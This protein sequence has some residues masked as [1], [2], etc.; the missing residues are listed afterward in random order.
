MVPF[1]SHG[2]EIVIAVIPTEQIKVVTPVMTITTKE[3]AA[4]RISG[5]FVDGVKVLKNEIDLL[6][7]KAA[8]QGKLIE[9]NYITGQE[10]KA[11]TRTP[12]RNMK[13]DFTGL[14]YGKKLMTR[15]AAED[16]GWRVIKEFSG[17]YALNVCEVEEMTA[18]EKI[19]A[20]Y[21]KLVD[22]AD[23]MTLQGLCL[24]QAEQLFIFKT[25]NPSDDRGFFDMA[26]EFKA[27][28]A[29][30]TVDTNETDG[31]EDDLDEEFI[32]VIPTDDSE[33]DDDELI[34]EPDYWDEHITLPTFEEIEI[35]D[36][37]NKPTL[38]SSNLEWT[39]LNVSPTINGFDSSTM[40]KS[41]T[42]EAA[43]IGNYTITISLK[44]KNN[45]QWAGGSTSDV[46]LNW[47]IVRKKLTAAQS[48][49]TGSWVFYD[50]N[51]K[52][53]R[54]YVT[55]IDDTYHTFTGQTSGTNAGTYSISISPRETYA[56]SD[57]TTDAKVTSMTITPMRLAK[58]SLTNTTFTYDSTAHS[59]TI[60]NFNSTY[61]N[62]VGSDTATN[63]GTYTLTFSLKNS[64]NTTWLDSTTSNVECTWTI[65]KA[66]PTLTLS[67]NSVTLADSYGAQATVDYTY[68]GDGTVSM[69]IPA[70]ADSDALTVVVE[71]SGLV[72]FT[73][74]YR[75]QAITVK[76]NASATKNYNAA[77]ATLSV[78]TQFVQPVEYCT[79]YD[80]KQILKGG[81]GNKLLA[82]GYLPNNSI[83][84]SGQNVWD[85][86]NSNDYYT[87]MTAVLLHATESEAYFAFAYNT[88]G[89]VNFV[90][91]N[92]YDST[93]SDNVYF[94][95]AKTITKGA[96]WVMNDGLYLMQQALFEGTPDLEQYLDTYKPT[97]IGV[98]R[99]L[100]VVN[101]DNNVYD[102]FK[103]GNYK[104]AAMPNGTYKYWWTSNFTDVG[105]K[106][107]YQHVRDNNSV[108]DWTYGDPPCWGVVFGFKMSGA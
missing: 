81:K 93:D 17:S 95:P 106:R 72:F 52:N 10:F 61:E 79:F 13:V 101:P 66:T 34:D 102:Y 1:L 86:T 15:S 55:G 29:Q 33:L 82:G 59:P 69:E 96:T 73:E 88:G 58:P 26:N 60:N 5:Y 89:L 90:N 103:N 7:Q 108:A 49:F 51:A 11:L 48:T 80:V 64:N 30:A 43:A 107:Y 21:R 77:S 56:W 76:V 6:I 46:V 71:D 74:K 57:G 87:K 23:V 83:Q 40:T 14:T 3:N 67:T 50:G 94:R 20:A 62:Q 39:G 22:F 45:T 75:A 28:N 92:Q 105:D 44:D 54:D 35:G 53:T 104:M 27:I 63:A 31:S 37:L 99:K 19:E 32:A 70:S 12:Y 98:K 78:Y 42:F 36:G 18:I 91:S 4:G 68:S 84:F 8:Q 9:V 100:W 38:A 85:V 16:L 2:S 25:L 41:G 65:N 97:N 24:R 47:H